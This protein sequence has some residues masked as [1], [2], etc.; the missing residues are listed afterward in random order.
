MFVNDTLIETPKVTTTVDNST[1]VDMKIAPEKSKNP[2][3]AALLS[4]FIPGAGQIYNGQWWKVPIIYG[5]AA[6]SLYFCKQNQKDWKYYDKEVIAR[7]NNDSANFDPKL[8]QY[9]L[10]SVKNAR[11]Y[12]R[13]NTELTVIITAAIYLLNIVDA[14][15]FAHLYSFDVS[16]RLTMQVKP[17][18]RTDFGYY[19]QKNNAFPMSGGLRISLTLK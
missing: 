2:T 15:V 9:S 11:D 6:V 5:G 16:D 14:T 17:Y 13:R 7:V 18:M 10:Q 4:T 12:Y 19:T 8:S 3:K 1:K